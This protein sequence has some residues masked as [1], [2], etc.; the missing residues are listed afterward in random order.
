MSVSSNAENSFWASARACE[1]KSFQ[2]KILPVMGRTYPGTPLGVGPVDL[3][4]Q[5][6]NSGATVGPKS[7]QSPCS[8]RIPLP[9]PCS[10]RSGW[11]RVLVGLLLQYKCWRDAVAEVYPHP[12]VPHAPAPQVDVEAQVFLYLRV[13]AEATP[14]P[15]PRTSPRSCGG[16]DLM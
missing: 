8:I 6:P 1:A 16:P 5:C 4:P 14:L 10:I 11:N 9:V 7:M 2:Q 13:H 3:P 12:T 15:A